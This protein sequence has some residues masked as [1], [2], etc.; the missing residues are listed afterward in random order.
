MTY[1][2]FAEAYKWSPRDI[3]NLEWDKVAKLRYLVEKIMEK[4][5]E[6]LD[7]GGDLLG[8]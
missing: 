6:N 4:K 3:E 7:I 1:I 8:F 5:R 2:L